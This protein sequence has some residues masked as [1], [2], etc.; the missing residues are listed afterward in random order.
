MVDQLAPHAVTS[1][2]LQQCR[3]HFG[4]SG[5]YARAPRM[6]LGQRAQQLG[7]PGRDPAVAA[8]PEKWDIRRVVKKPVRLLQ[9]IQ[10]HG[11][12]KRCAVQ[13]LRVASR[14]I[15]LH[16][17]DGDHVHVI[18]P[19]AGLNSEAVGRGLGPLFISQPPS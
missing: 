8:S 16:L 14:A 19:I 9:I 7:H 2:I 13:I 6:I 1:L 11:H 10:V 17:G 3:H 12:F 18:N 5:Q 15:S 4:V